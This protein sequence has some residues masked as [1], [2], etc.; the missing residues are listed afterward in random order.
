MPPISSLTKKLAEAEAHAA[1]Y[2]ARVEQLAEDK[3][4][5]FRSLEECRGERSASPSTVDVLKTAAVFVVSPVNTAGCVPGS[6]P[7][8]TK[9]CKAA[10]AAMDVPFEDLMEVCSRFIYGGTALWDGPSSS[11]AALCRMAHRAATWPKV[12]SSSTHLHTVPHTS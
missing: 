7:I 2:S 8:G 3:A 9:E 1:M 6:K 5:L 10:A 12:A 11:I 4:V